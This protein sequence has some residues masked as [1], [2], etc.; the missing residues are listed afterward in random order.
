ML[1]SCFFFCRKVL[2]L[3]C[4]WFLGPWNCYRFLSLMNSS[5]SYFCFTICVF[6]PNLSLS[7]EGKHLSSNLRWKMF[8]FSFTFSE[9]LTWKCVA[10]YLKLFFFCIV[11]SHNIT[12]KTL[13][14]LFYDDKSL[15]HLWRSLFWSLKLLLSTANWISRQYCGENLFS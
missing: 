15:L 10:E 14:T 7:V 6:P 13:T 5:D 2:C 11:T 9:S 4:A 1:P 8:S 12:L 3:F